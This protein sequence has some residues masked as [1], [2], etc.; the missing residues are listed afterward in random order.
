MTD[1]IRIR[2]RSNALFSAATED[3]LLREQLASDPASI[4][5]DYIHGERLSADEAAAS[6]HLLQ[7]LL[8]NDASLSWLEEL[9]RRLDLESLSNEQ[10][11]EDLS[12][13]MSRSGDRA[14][15]ASVL[16]YAALPTAKL[17]TGFEILRALLHAMPR[18]SGN[19]AL[20]PSGTENTPI[21]G[22]GHGTEHT[23]TTG[24]GHGTE[25]TPISGPKFGTE[26][27]PVTGT[28]HG[29]EHT[30]VTGTGHGTEHTPVT[31]TGH[32]TEHTPVTGGHGTEHTPIT[33]GRKHGAKH[34]SR[35]A[36]GTEN[37]PIT[38]TGHGTEHTPITGT[39]H[40]T[41]HTPVT[42]TE[43]GTEH[44]PAGG[45]SS[46]TSLYASPL[47]ALIRYA[48]EMRRAGELFKI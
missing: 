8:S 4:L 19:G 5:Y 45:I 24:T 22:T 29:T 1:S 6:N 42:G 47:R 37:T 3:F 12:L 20:H 16:R 46:G 21:T 27:T 41:E 30:P 33:G 18:S 17:N 44:T 40:G 38:G 35:R 11:A 43:H 48:E 26:N 15:A 28:G 39:G 36:S 2:H 32:G 10:M 14:V 9:A 13:H 34:T 31:G 25:H 7:A 23:P